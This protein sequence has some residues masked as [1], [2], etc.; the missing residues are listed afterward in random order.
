[1]MT[2][3]FCGVDSAR[4]WSSGEALKK[5]HLQFLTW[6][7]VSMLSFW[8]IWPLETLKNQVQAGTALEGIAAPTLRQRVAHL[9]LMGLYRGILP[10]SLSVFLRNGSAAVAGYPKRNLARGRSK[11]KSFLIRDTRLGCQPADHVH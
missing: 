5:P 11:L 10:G 6:G 2:C 3:I 1:M 9:G 7:G 4:R 8:V